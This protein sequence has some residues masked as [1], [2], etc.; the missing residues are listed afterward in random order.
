MKSVTRNRRTRKLII[1]KLVR[2]PTRILTNKCIGV[3]GAAQT[4]LLSH[5]GEGATILLIIHDGSTIIQQPETTNSVPY[6]VTLIFRQSDFH[7]AF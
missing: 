7:T 2:I 6:S 4:L 1:R 5:S 3:N